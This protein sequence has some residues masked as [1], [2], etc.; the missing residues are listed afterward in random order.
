MTVFIAALVHETNTFSPLPTTRRS[1]SEGVLHQTGNAQT[2]AEAKQLVGYCD[3]LAIAAATGEH[4]ICGPAALA[5][6]A[7][8]VPR[9]VYETLRDDLIADLVAA[10]PVDKVFLLLHGA[11]VAEGYADAEGDLL[12]KVRAAVGPQVAIGALLDLHGNISRAMI[13]SAAV[14][15]AVKEY[16]HTDY[17]ERAHELYA[18]LESIA[19][20]GPVPKTVLRRVPLLGTFGTTEPPMRAFVERMQ[21]F[22]KEPGIRSVSTMHGFPWADTPHTSGC[23]IVVHDAEAAL[24]AEQIADELAAAFFA[25]RLTVPARLP[26]DAA[27]DKALAELS[28]NGPV[29]IGDGADNPGGGAACDSTF[30][31]EALLARGVENAALGM[32]WDPQA[33]EI[34]ADAG[35]GARL[36]LR[37][38]GKVGPMSGRPLDVEAEVLCVRD[39]AVQPSIDSTSDD[40]LGAAVAIRVG[41]IDVVLNSTRQQVFTPDC[42]TEFGIDVRSKSIVVVKSTQHFRAGFDPIAAAT[43]YCD[44][45]GSLHGDLA[46]LPY[47]RL[48]RPIWPLDRFDAPTVDDGV[49]R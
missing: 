40:P 6:P 35:V 11:M 23:V 39:D 15:V 26:I 4:A 2:L 27:I 20:G 30:V 49:V 33:V 17:S 8:T 31:L 36:S 25:L 34:A 28:P 46:Q 7:G 32:I 38:G 14:L 41:G 13:E 10:G 22:E 48:R 5:Q 43:I 37:I 29:V 42:F 16:P 24:R 21:A 19:A 44:A 47:R 18:I 9:Q 45:P 12:Q 3:A 1:F